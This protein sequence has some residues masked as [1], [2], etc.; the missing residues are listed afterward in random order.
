MVAACNLKGGN[1]HHYTEAG[2]PQIQ[3]ERDENMKNRVAMLSALFA[4]TSVVSFAA[5]ID[6]KW[7]AET[8]GRNGP[9]TQTLMLKADGAKLTGSL[10]G[11]RGGATDITEGKI[12]GANV[13][14]KIERAGRDGAKQVT[15]YTGTLMGDDLTLT[16][17]RDAGAGGGGGGGGKGG[18]PMPLAFK[19][20]K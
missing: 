18:A 10:D 14:F 17:M 19:R 20:A 2:Y 15:T 1:G 16:P 13:T 12:D 4:L 9:Q 3:Q 11:G 8:Q 7:T 5:A 6:G